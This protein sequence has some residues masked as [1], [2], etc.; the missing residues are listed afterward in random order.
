MYQTHQ[1]KYR[2]FL[3]SVRIIVWYIVECLH[4]SVVTPSLCKGGVSRHPRGVPAT[5]GGP[6]HPRWGPRHPGAGGVPATCV[7]GGGRAFRHVVLQQW[8]GALQL[9]EA[10]R[11]RNS[12]S[13]VTHRLLIKKKCLA[14]RNAQ[15]R[16]TDSRSVAG[17]GRRITLTHGERLS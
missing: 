14:K 13:Y 17:G 8:H 4:N 3:N 9:H 15:Y 7:V 12:I 1:P 5:Q 2:K 11:R 10:T 16:G 6:R